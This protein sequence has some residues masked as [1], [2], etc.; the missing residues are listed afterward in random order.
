M[1]SAFETEPPVKSMDQTL[2]EISGLVS[3]PEIYLKFRRLMEDP[4]SD[5]EDFSGLVS[6]DPNLAGTVLKVVNSAFFG[7]PGQID[8][9][10]RAVNLLG[11]GTLHD[12]VLGASAVSALDFPNDI[13]PLKTFWR[14]SIFSGV[15]ARLLSNQLKIRKSESLFVIGLLHDIG[16]L[17]IYSKYPNQAKQILASLL[18]GNKMLHD[19]EL[20]ILGFHYGQIGASLMA[21]WQLPLNFQVITYYQ[22]TPV[23]APEHPLA[24]AVLHL[25]HAYAQ[26]SYAETSQTIEQ[27][28]NPSAWDILNLSPEQVENLLEKTQE[29]CAEMEKA[30]LK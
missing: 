19:L 26:K 10:G 23:Y 12:M 14:C 13:V 29:T 28:V 4:N 22:P 8:S 11:I 24:T 3:L 17:I 2:Q 18:E 15:M 6:S 30:I 16:H 7:F 5:I 20:S 21:Q 25:A 27:L 9:I 1:S